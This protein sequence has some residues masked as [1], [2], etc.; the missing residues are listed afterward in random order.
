MLLSFTFQLVKSNLIFNF[1]FS[2]LSLWHSL[3][4]SNSL[5][6]LLLCPGIFFFFIKPVTG[7]CF[8]GREVKSEWSFILPRKISFQ[9]VSKLVEWSPGGPLCHQDPFQWSGCP[10]TGQELPTRGVMGTAQQEVQG[11][12]TTG[13]SGTS[14]AKKNRTLVPW[15]Q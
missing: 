11:H 5:S 6:T 2:S 10:F 9:L 4:I 15:A 3:Y 1:S 12:R 14:G 8:V 13:G 7:I